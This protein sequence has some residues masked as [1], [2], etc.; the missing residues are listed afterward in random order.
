MTSPRTDLFDD[1][2]GFVRSH[3]VQVRLREMDLDKP[4]EFDGPTI[5]IN[6]VHDRQACCYYLAHSLGSIYQWSTDFEH[7]QKVFE[8]LRDAKKGKQRG[9]EEALDRWRKF[10]EVSSD[11]AVW[12]LAETGHQE[13]I[14]P[15]TV[16]FRADIEAMTIFHR[17]GKEP[18]WPDFFASWKEGI[19]RGEIQIEP[20]APKAVAPFRPR[21]IEKQEVLQEHD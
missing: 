14:D 4:G 8:E 13:E 17:T 7:A 21:R 9:F 1:L 12:I 19:A 11:H 20:F 3:G 10:E 18:R 6:P 16:F 5:T 15:Y 2:Q